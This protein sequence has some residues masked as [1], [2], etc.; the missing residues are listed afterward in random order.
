MKVL[1]TG[2]A[3]FIGTN[4]VLKLIET[5]HEITILD[6][7]STG[8][9][10]NVPSGVTFTEGSITD[11]KLVNE[12]SSK[13]DSIIHL[14]A[15][16]SVP[17]SIKN[18]V[19]T[20]DVNVNGTLNI[21]EAARKHHLHVIFSSSSSVYGSNT[22]L[23]KREDM[24]LR[25]LTPYAASKLS[26]EGLMS[27]YG[28]T[29]DL[30]I[31]TLRFFNVFGPWQRPDHAYSAVIPK[32]IWRA[33]NNEVIEVYG[34]GEQTRDFTSVTTV[35]EVI[36]QALERRL[37]H[38]YPINLAFGNRISLNQIINILKIRFANL[39][40]EYQ[41]ER[42]G[43]VYSSQNDPSLVKRLFSNIKHEPFEESLNR[44]IEWMK[45]DSEKIVGGP[46]VND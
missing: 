9:R 33:M 41:G 4:V 16:G 43:D 20:Y 30:D 34:D 45:F 10:S 46:A 39:E 14:A 2:G 31:T 13:V 1:V 42:P 44:T 37:N 18:P 40:V 11:S 26:G 28:E 25:P 6:D 17:R 23:P 8:L 27:A 5:G 36:S 19:L 22:E 32:W 35:L 24:V 15:R 29:Y 7:L 3:G 38:P 21:L 12:L